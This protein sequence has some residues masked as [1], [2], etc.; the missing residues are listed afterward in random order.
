M[1]MRLGNVLVK[2]V[3]FENEKAYKKVSGDQRD[4]YGANVIS[5]KTDVCVINDRYF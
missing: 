2:R 1:D 3:L 4:L 5:K